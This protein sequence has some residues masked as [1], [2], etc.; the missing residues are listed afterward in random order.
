MNINIIEKKYKELNKV[1][2]FYKAK[3]DP[4]VKN[5]YVNRHTYFHEIKMDFVEDLNT[6]GFSP[7]ILSKV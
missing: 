5:P 1:D 2:E 3:Q 7:Y 4:R 6:Y